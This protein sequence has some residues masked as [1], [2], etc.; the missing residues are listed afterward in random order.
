MGI[1]ARPGG[2]RGRPAACGVI[3]TW[4]TRVDWLLVAILAAALL[5]RLAYPALVGLPPRTP[6]SGFVIDEAEYYGA[7]SGLADGRG[8]SFYATF[9]W[10]RVPAYVFFVA[11][12]FLLAGRAVAPVF[13]AQAVLSTRDSV[14]AGLA[15]GAGGGA[16]LPASGCP[17]VP[18]SEAPR[19]SARSGCRLPSSPICCSARR[20]SC[21]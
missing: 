12:L 13:A 9:P 21:C 14:G 10:T 11:G 20:S 8:L 7:A 5:I 17:G 6:V 19:R 15:G 2:A 1:A 3:G 16:P 4:R 18:P